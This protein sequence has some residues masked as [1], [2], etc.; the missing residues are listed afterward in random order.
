MRTGGKVPKLFLMVAFMLASIESIARENSGLVVSSRGE[1]SVISNDESRPL[2]HGDYIYEHDKI[3]VG[4]RSFAVLQLADGAKLTLRPESSLIIEQYL[5]EGIDSDTATLN[6]V[7]GSL[8]VVAGAIAHTQPGNYRIRTP[9]ALMSVQ[10]SESSL[11]LC[12][13]KICDQRGLVEISE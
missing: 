6:L 4:N 5:Y 3:I 13:D 9:V 12:G 1:V 11:N 2:K 10:G 7:S 8:R